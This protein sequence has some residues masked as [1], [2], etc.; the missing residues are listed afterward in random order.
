M[1]I[2]NQYKPF[3]RR[4]NDLASMRTSCLLFTGIYLFASIGIGAGIGRIFEQVL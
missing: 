1:V 4:F 3:F 2:L